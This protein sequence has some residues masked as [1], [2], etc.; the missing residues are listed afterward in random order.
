MNDVRHRS[1]LMH[2][3]NIAPSA[4]QPQYEVMGVGFSE[5]NESPSAKT[6]SKRYIHQKTETKRVIGYDW[7]TSFNTDQIRNDKVVDYIC[8]IG[9]LQL[10]GADAETDYI[11]V[12]SDKPGTETNTFRARKFRVAIEVASFDDNDGELAVTGNL[13]SVSDLVVGTFNTETKAFT[14]GFTPKTELHL[15]KGE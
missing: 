11:V 3:L 4:V 6:A 14:D 13:L 1:I 5:L 15:N 10:I 9:E 2:Y 12:D 8:N 7:S